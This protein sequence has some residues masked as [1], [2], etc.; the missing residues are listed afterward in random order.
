MYPTCTIQTQATWSIKPWHAAEG[1]TWQQENASYTR[2]Y[3]NVLLDNINAANGLTS[4]DAISI[5]SCATAM[6]Q[7]SL[8]HTSCNLNTASHFTCS[9]RRNGQ[10]LTGVIK[11]TDVGG[12]WMGADLELVC[13]DFEGKASKRLLVI[14]LPCHLLL[15]VVHSCALHHHTNCLSAIS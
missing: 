4:S 5:A 3:G 6:Q 9:D 12:G 7:Q 10:D 11:E 1:L 14:R 13:H 8:R 15:W 2:S